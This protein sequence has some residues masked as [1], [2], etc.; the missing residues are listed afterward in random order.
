MIFPFTRNLKNKDLD[1]SIKQ[2]V[3]THHEHAD[4]SGFPLGVDNK[5]LNP[6]QR[7]IEIVD[8]YDTL[9][10]RE[11]GFKRMSPF[12]VL[13]QLNEVEGN[14]YDIYIKACTDFHTVQSAA[15]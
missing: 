4:G 11:P 10:M 3:L 6:I 8:V 7:V 14:K 13:I 1:Q 12:E 5:S 9:L 15:E 2:A